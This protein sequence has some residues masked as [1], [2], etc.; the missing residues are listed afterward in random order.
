MKNFKILAI[1][2]FFALTAAFTLAGINLRADKSKSYVAYN[3][4]HPLHSWRG[5]NKNVD[6]IIVFDDKANTISKVAVSANVSDFDSGNSNRDSHGLEVLNALTYPKV[7]FIST[8]I[9][10]NGNNLK[11]DGNLTFH[12]VTKSISFNATREDSDKEIK[13][14]G[15]FPVSMAAHNIESPSFMMMS[16]EDNLKMEVYMVFKKS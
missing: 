12:G 5:E 14:K 16:T 3:A 7:T 8:S 1:L 13:V 4:V 9:T 6:C 11:I 2:G 10:A 15:E